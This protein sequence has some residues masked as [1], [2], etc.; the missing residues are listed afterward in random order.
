VAERRRRQRPD[1]DLTDPADYTPRRKGPPEGAV[2]I[3]DKG[4]ALRDHVAKLFST[5]KLSVEWTDSAS[6][7]VRLCE[8]TAVA[9]VLINTSTPGVDPYT[10]CAQIKQ[11][12]SANRVAVV[13]LVGDSFPY[14]ASRARAAGVRGL[15]DKPVADRH[16]EATIK[17]LLSLP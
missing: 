3:V 4:A 12:D 10:L 2:L 7:A 9:V 5:R 11:L 14:H 13:L 8:E 1:F 17:K 6:T 15:L 16:L